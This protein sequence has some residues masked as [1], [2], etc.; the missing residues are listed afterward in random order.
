[1][2]D[3]SAHRS[4]EG[5]P[6]TRRGF[7]LAL[8]VSALQKSIRR[9]Q[10]EAA[11]YWAL[12]MDN[13]GFCAYAFRRLAVI[14]SED[15]G[16]AEPTLPAT[17]EALRRS[18]ERER[19]RKKW[20]TGGLFLVHATLLLARAPKSRI[21]DNALIAVGADQE[22]RAIPDEALDVHTR[23]GRQRG[24]GWQHFIED[25]G[26]LADR[27]TGELG[28]GCLP[29]PYRER[30]EAALRASIVETGRAATPRHKQLTIEEEQ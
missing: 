12:E 10:E 26:L 3:R 7:E 5:P 16:L 18:W 17:I 27:E 15:V 22:P 29:D 13:S 2:S 8:V 30:A 6:P 9:G 4:G 28:H 20:A 23:T 14:C 24:R 11:V 1:M 19:E 25:S 21:V